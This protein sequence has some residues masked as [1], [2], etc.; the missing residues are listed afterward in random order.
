MLAR[1]KSVLHPLV[2]KAS[3]SGVAL[4]LDVRERVGRPVGWGGA[5]DFGD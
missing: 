2:G 3:A 4:G 5:V 1:L